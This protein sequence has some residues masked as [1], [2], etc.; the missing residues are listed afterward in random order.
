[1][2]RRRGRREVGEG[3][4]NLAFNLAFYTVVYLCVVQAPRTQ[5]RTFKALASWLREQGEE[6]QA[7]KKVQYCKA[8]QEEYDDEV[9][10][11][12]PAS[13]L[14]PPSP[15]LVGLKQ[16]YVRK[17]YPEISALIKTRYK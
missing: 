11:E 1:M 9:E 2:R 3:A 17:C 8:E 13:V 15:F 12:A 16:L 14:T 4:F 10:Q 6:N 7:S 5:P